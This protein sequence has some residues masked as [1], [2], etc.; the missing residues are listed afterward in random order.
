MDNSLAL[1]KDIASAPNRSS[2]HTVVDGK[3]RKI[4]YG[5]IDNIA[6]AGSISSSVKDMSKWVMA[7]LDGGK[8]DG[9]QVIPGAAISQTWTPHSILGN[10]GPSFNT[11]HFALYGLGWFLEEY[12]GKKIVS[13]TGGVNG[14]VTAVTLI[15]EEKLG[16]IVL[17][18]TDA[19]NFYEALKQEIVDAMLGLKYRNYHQSAWS[20]QESNNK[21]R[22]KQL[23]AKNDTIS[24]KPATVLPL[25]NFA[26]KYIHDVYGGMS[27]EVKNGKLVASFEHHKGRY[28]ELEPLGGARFLATFNDPLYGIKVWPF[29]VDNGKV[30]SVTVRVADFVEFL[31]YE[32]RKLE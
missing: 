16:V 15:P 12:N 31:P 8:L 18:N 24:A 5:R 27:I 10:G 4:A 17:T 22:A 7:Q 26:G 19:N 29:N 3:L 9:R 2:A 30:K 20:A 23:K 11:G 13:H 28:A 32:F 1:S 14:F 21:E 25:A 6:P